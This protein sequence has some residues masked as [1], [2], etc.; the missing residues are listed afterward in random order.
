MASRSWAHA[1]K[2]R[3][4]K[5]WAWTTCGRKDSRR[6]EGELQ[7]NTNEGQVTWRL[8]HAGKKRTQAWKKNG[9]AGR[10][11]SLANRSRELGEKA[12]KPGVDHV[13]EETAKPASQQAWA[14]LCLAVGPATDGP[15][16]VELG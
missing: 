1:R 5:P 7:Q 10:K 15:S 14:Y 11:E 6:G 8:L 2:E 12:N 13:R 3:R 16:W 4:S 9:P